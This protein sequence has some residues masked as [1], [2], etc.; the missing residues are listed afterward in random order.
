MQFIDLKTQYQQLKSNI[1]QRIQGICERAQFIMGPEVAELEQ[2]LAAYVGAKHCIGVAN[3]TDALQI[4][5]LALDIGPGDEVITPAFSFIA[6]VEMIALLGATPVLIDIDPKTYNLDPT[7]LKSLINEN[8]KAIVPISLYGQCP[9][10]NSINEIA[11]QHNIPVIEDAA[12]S[13]GATSFD[14]K[15]C[16]ATTIATT[17]FFP[18]KPLGGYG[19]GGACFTN[20][21]ALAEMMKAMRVHGAAKRYQ[22]TTLGMNSRLDTLQAAILLEKLAVYP[23]E[24]QQRQQ[25]TALYAKYLSDHVTVPFIAEGNT[26]AFAQYTI[27]VPERDRVQEH[28]HNNNIPTAVHYLMPIHWQAAYTDIA[29]RNAFPES[30]RASQEVISL[31]FHPYLT[32]DDIK[33]V[34][35][36]VIEALELVSA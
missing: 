27:R 26:S 20:D 23:Q 14:K 19:D 15:S 13:F 12:Q 32:E 9:D 6:V 29:P 7:Q 30:I 22:H 4:A 25:C 24:F 5:L 28:L 16:N 2:Q 8:T 35:Q 33:T 21:D 31:P 1:D 3:G 36:T 11:G 18:S 17:S 34:S 10:F